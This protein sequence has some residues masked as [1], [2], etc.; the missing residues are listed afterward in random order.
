MNEENKNGRDLI[1]CRELLENCE[2]AIKR[3]EG[4]PEEQQAEHLPDVI[5][6]AKTAVQIAIHAIDGAKA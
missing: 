6:T 3:L 4:L 1:K 5:A 2:A